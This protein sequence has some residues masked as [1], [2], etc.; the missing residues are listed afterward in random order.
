M[1]LLESEK[2]VRLGIFLGIFFALAIVAISE[3]I[4]INLPMAPQG[5]VIGLAQFLDLRQLSLLRVLI[6]PFPGDS[7]AVP[8]NRR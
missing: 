5:Y 1:D 8:I 3:R 6:L 4:K 7:G 2:I